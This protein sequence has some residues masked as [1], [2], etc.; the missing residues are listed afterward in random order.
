MAELLQV[1]EVAAGATEVVVAE[2]LVDRRRRAQGRRSDRR[3]R[4][5]EGRRRDGGRDRRPPSSGPWWTPGPPWTSG[6]R[7]RCSAAPT[8]CP[9]TS[10]RSSPVSASG[11]RRG[12]RA[13]RGDVPETEAESPA[14]GQDATPQRQADRGTAGAVEGTPVAASSSARSPASCCAMPGS[15]PDGITGSRPNGRIR[16]RDVEDVPRGARLPSTPPQ[17][18]PMPG[19]VTAGPSSRSRSRTARS[20]ECL[21]RRA[22]H[23]S[24]AGRS[25]A[26]SPRA[27]R[28]CRTSTS[29]APWCSTTCSPSARRLNE[30][31]PVKISVNDFLIRAIAVAH[32]RRARGERHLDR[33]RDAALRRRRRR[34]GDRLR[35]GPRHARAAWRREALAVPRS[36]LRSRASSSRPTRGRLQQQDLEGG[37]ITISNLGMYGVEEFSAIINP[38]Q[39]AILAV[40]AGRRTPAV[41]D[42]AVVV[43]TTAQLVLSVD[44]RAIDGALAAQWMARPR[45]RAREPPPPRRLTAARPTR[46]RRAMTHDF[47]VVVL[48]GGSGGYAAALRASQLGKSVA[49][50]ERDRLGGTCLH[51]GACR[52]RRCCTPRSSPTLPATARRTG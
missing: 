38:P 14:P 2:W 15:T 44:H 37:S 19:A 49:L 33:G 42:G 46:A 8:S 23:P 20:L 45:D 30:A 40:G 39:S 9:R 43:R 4:D 29:S 32:R 52:P 21:D 51:R 7:W 1:P 27:S 26:G 18:L 24:C 10:T 25:R 16:R 5:R 13:P 36:P 12:S 48:G 3:D 11:D 17:R 6:R 50:V 28:T 31:S 41:V 22:A 47:D 35:A 34:R